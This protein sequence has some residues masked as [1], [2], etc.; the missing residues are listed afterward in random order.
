MDTHP[1]TVLLQGDTTL[2]AASTASDVEQLHRHYNRAHGSGKTV[3]GSVVSSIPEKTG[4]LTYN[5]VL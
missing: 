4:G 3:V 5:R 1:L 2:T